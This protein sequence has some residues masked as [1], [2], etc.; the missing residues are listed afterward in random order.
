[1]CPIGQAIY[2]R[3]RSRQALYA[4]LSPFTAPTVCTL[5]LE[6]VR[7]A[8]THRVPHSLPAA[9]AVPADAGSVPTAAG[10]DSREE[11]VGAD[12][13]AEGAVRLTLESYPEISQL[14]L[15]Y[16]VRAVCESVSVS[17]HASASASV[18]WQCA[19]V[20]MMSTCGW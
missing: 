11:A 7:K 13:D 5:H 3:V 1:M 2:D 4:A 16:Q 10:E 17:V 14:P 8:R 9:D 19:L 18:T 15:E 6:V 20:A 12:G